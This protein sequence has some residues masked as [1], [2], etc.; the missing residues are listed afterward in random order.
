MRL[1]KFY[2]LL[3]LSLLFLVF[4]SVQIAVAENYTVRIGA[5]LPFT[6]DLA[7]V[8]Q[9][10]REGV[11]LALLERGNQQPK[12]E[13]IWEDG[14]FAPKES[15]SAAQKLISSD[16]VDLIISLWDTADVIAPISEK[17]KVIQLSIRWNPDV[18]AR[19]KYTFTFESTYPTYYADIVKLIKKQISLINN[20]SKN[21][22]NSILLIKFNCIIKIEAN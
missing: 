16:K 2:S 13:V 18:A 11:E 19:N 7:Y 3:F 1:T 22:T 4:F 15:V 6:G 21:Y 9:D 12:I 8:G 20:L 10:I 14:K 5:V 17:A